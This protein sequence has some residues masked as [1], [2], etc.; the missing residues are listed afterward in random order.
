[1][2]P[3]PRHAPGSRLESSSC[4]WFM[5]LAL[6]PKWP[7]I[8]IE[9]PIGAQQ[10]L[11][12]H[13]KLLPARAQRNGIGRLF[14]PITAI[15][16]TVVGRADRATARVRNRTKTRN[17]LRNHHANRAAQFTLHTHAVRRDSGLGLVQV[18]ADHLEQLVL[19]DRAAVQF[20]IDRHMSGDGRGG[21]ERADLWVIHCRYLAFEEER[22]LSPTI[23]EKSV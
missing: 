9:G 1:M 17:A 18:G 10:I 12:G 20:K 13:S 23:Y 3:R 22:M 4:S 6:L 11:L 8:G 19:V 15:T 14:R 7:G 2:L 5:R 21:T 16:A